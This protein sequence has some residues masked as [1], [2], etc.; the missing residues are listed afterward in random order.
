VEEVEVFLP[1]DLPSP[2]LQQEIR[3]SLARATLNPQETDI[4]SFL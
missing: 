4:F 2:V 1:F 3:G